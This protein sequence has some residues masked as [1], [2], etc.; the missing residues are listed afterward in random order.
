MNEWISMGH[1]CTDRDNYSTQRKTCHSA[2]AGCLQALRW[3]LAWPTGIATHTQ[4]LTIYSGAK[5]TYI[6]TQ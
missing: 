5:K 2:F 1:W 3:H 6:P 4:S